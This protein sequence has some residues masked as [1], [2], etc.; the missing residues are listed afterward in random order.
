M[1][2]LHV[3]QTSSSGVLGEERHFVAVAEMQFTFAFS[4]FEGGY[5]NDPSP[6][7]DYRVATALTFEG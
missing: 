6:T 7:F 3:A 1:A 2:A 4:A 5:R